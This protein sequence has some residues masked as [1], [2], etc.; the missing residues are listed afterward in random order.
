L[1]M[2]KFMPKLQLPALVVVGSKSTNM[3]SNFEKQHGW[4]QRPN[5]KIIN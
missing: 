1:F 2:P 3:L 5:A 4:M